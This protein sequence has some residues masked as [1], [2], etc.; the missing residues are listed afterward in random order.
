MIEK[1]KAA[2][3]A[4]SKAYFLSRPVAHRNRFPKRKALCSSVGNGGMGRRIAAV[5]VD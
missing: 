1:D 3:A 2:M 5:R 4:T